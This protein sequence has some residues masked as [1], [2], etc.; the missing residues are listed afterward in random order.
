[1]S[2]KNIRRFFL[3]T[4]PDSKSPT[5]LLPQGDQIDLTPFGD[6]MMYLPENMGFSREYGFYTLGSSK[7]INYETNPLPDLTFSYTAGTQ[8]GGNYE[9]FYRFLLK[10]KGR[11]C[12]L[13]YQNDFGILYKDVRLKQLDLSEVQELD[14]LQGTLV[15]ESL[16]PWYYRVI[17]D[18][19]IG[20]GADITTE[21]YFDLTYSF[22]PRFRFGSRPIETPGVWVVPEL[23]SEDNYY[24]IDIVIYENMN[25]IT[26]IYNDKEGVEYGRDIIT[27]PF[28]TDDILTITY[29]TVSLI[30][31]GVYFDISYCRDYTQ[32]IPE[33][34]QKFTRI[35]GLAPDEQGFR[36]IDFYSVRVK[37][38]LY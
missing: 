24:E 37:S 4:E 21:K 31:N 8:I 20:S 35:V 11:N 19:R 6:F 23:E 34:F 12:I 10:Y 18:Y 5:E 28:L 38:F 2:V 27:Y 22:K 29:Q 3:L 26:L 30:R 7:V 9:S 33:T 13:C 14:V 32:F 36:D 15:F 25:Q 17:R 16:T 1:M